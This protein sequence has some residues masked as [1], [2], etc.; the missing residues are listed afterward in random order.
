MRGEAWVI[1]RGEDYETRRGR[2]VGKV[3]EVWDLG[4]RTQEGEVGG[5]VYVRVDIHGSSGRHSEE[6]NGLLQSKRW[7]SLYL[8]VHLTQ[9]GPRHGLIL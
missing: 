7:Q 1:I 5:W 2:L 3:K 4:A 8:V 6:S 9:L